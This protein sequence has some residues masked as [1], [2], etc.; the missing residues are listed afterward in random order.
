MACDLFKLATP[1]VAGLQ[2]Y[3]P[4]KPVEELERELGIENIVKLASNENPLGPGVKAKQAILSTSEI[5]RYPDGN[6]HGLKM[7]LAKYHDVN[8]DQITIG[9]GSSEILELITRAVTEPQHE[10]IYSDHAFAV[11]PLVTQAVGA[12]AVVVPAKDWGH[13]IVAMQVAINKNSRIMFIANPNN[14]TGTW[15]DKQ[16]LRTLLESSPEHMVIVLDEA[17]FEYVQE[18][19]YPNCVQ[20]VNEFP[21]LLVTRTFSKAFGLAGLRI[22]YGISHKDIADLMNRVR[23][24]FNV[25]SL[26]LSAAEAALADNEH[27]Q[28]SS[29]LNQTGMAQLTSAFDGMGLQ[30][31]PSVG[32]FICINV[33][34]SGMEIYKKLLHEGVIVRPVDN[35]GMPNHLRITVGLEEENEKFINALDKVLTG[36]SAVP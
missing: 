2:P 25:N 1:G 5:S 24:P 15:L 26:A 33:K 13:D 28:Q 9:N 27:L 19:D 8:V 35:Y 34:Q 3:Q 10:I 6:A 7:A 22:G 32:N 29:K 21:H 20:W 36:M 11:Y 17:Y 31:I 4:G 16:T 30:Y 23:Q 12:K 18:D 14:P